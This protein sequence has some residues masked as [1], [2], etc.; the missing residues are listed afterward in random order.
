MGHKI[1]PERV[2]SDSLMILN[3]PV[4]KYLHSSARSK[5]FRAFLKRSGGYLPMI[6]RIFAEP[7]PPHDLI[8]LA[9]VE[10]GFSRYGRLPDD[11]LGILQFTGGTARR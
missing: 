7:S 2:T 4:H 8:Y 1:L 5:D 10:S 3:V 9:L 11:V 6:Q